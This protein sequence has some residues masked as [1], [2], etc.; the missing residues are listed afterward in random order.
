MKK[1]CKSA[2]QEHPKICEDFRKTKNEDSGDF[3]VGGILFPSSENIRE[4]RV[5]EHNHV[6]RAC[7]MSLQHGKRLPCA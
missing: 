5:K 6:H 4:T 3:T 2:T 1:S 7:T